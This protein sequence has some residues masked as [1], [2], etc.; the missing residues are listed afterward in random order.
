[1]TLQEILEAIDHLT[2]EEMEQVRS[3]IIERTSSLVS[4]P[5]SDDLDSMLGLFQSNVTD[6][7]VNARRYLHD[8]FRDKHARSG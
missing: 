8:I 3:R 5:E 4:E 7:S 6:A 2:V 1:M